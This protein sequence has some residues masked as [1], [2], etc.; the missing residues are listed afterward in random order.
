M[1][2]RGFTL[3]EMLIVVGLIAVLAAMVL[4][5]LTRAR[6]SARLTTCG[7]N[8]RQMGTALSSYAAERKNFPAYTHYGAYNFGI[9][10]NSLGRSTWNW[11]LPFLNLPGQGFL[12]SKNAGYCTMSQAPAY[13]PWNEG[14][15]F[16]FRKAAKDLAGNDWYHSYLINEQ[17]NFGDYYYLGPGTHGYRWSLPD[18]PTMGGSPGM[19][20]GVHYNN[21]VYKCNANFGTAHD[22]LVDHVV[23][24]S[25]TTAKR[26][27]L[28]GD[29]TIYFKKPPFNISAP[30]YR[31]HSSKQNIL[32]TD[33]SVQVYAGP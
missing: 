3:L 28:M 4:A 11:L 27:P 26:L 19:F 5:A 14:V 33:G 10:A 16:G 32:F 18:F 12:K 30:H 31:G 21:Q 13:D 15:D 24:G 2:R 1:D 22:P 8:L 9:H 25:F 23:D 7:T 17:W 6:E 29:P 20:A